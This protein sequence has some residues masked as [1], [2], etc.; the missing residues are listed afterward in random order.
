[1][2]P[3]IHIPIPSDLREQTLPS[4]FVSELFAHEPQLNAG[5]RCRDGDSRVNIPHPFHT[6]EDITE[7]TDSDG[8]EEGSRERRGV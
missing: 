3:S 5:S 6:H 1:M 8:A 4:R 7:L 2:N